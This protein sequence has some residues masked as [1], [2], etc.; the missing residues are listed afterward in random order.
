MD[1]SKLLAESKSEILEGIQHLEYSYI[2]AMKLSTELGKLTSEDLET[3][4]GLIARF[5]R[6]SDIFLSKY[7]R[8]QVSNQEPGFRGSFRDLLDLA[9]KF[10][11]IDNADFWAQ[12]REL[13]NSSVHEYSKIKV[14]LIF[15]K[16]REL[17]P[18]L[19]ELKQ[20]LK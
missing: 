18:K 3:W 5:G 15:A 20:K 12:V 11:L 19:I 17:T 7:L 1:Y 9:E 14:P 6:V 16:V 13:R 2:K 10:R 8:T 4:E